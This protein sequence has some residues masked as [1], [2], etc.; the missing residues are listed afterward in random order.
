MGARDPGDILPSIPVWPISRSGPGTIITMEAVQ[1]SFW[2]LCVL[3]SAAATPSQL[4]A[5]SNFSVGPAGLS[6]LLTSVPFQEDGAL[7]G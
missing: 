2:K 1:G 3:G 5:T 4:G 6:S 7:S